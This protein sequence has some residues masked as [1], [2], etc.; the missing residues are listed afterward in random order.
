VKKTIY[1][2]PVHKLRILP[3]LTICIL[4]VGSLKIIYI[5]FLN[6]KAIPVL[7]WI[8]HEDFGRLRLPGFLTIGALQW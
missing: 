4:V 8:V 7:A 6:L 1:F 5:L 2:I 3:P